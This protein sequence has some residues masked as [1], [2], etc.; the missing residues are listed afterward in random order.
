[1]P[2]PIQK[3]AANWAASESEIGSQK[4]RRCRFKNRQ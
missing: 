1:M 2:L 3:L 4:L